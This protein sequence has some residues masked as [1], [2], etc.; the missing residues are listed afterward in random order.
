MREEGPEKALGA[1][2]SLCAFALPADSGGK[3]GRERG[4]EPDTEE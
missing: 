3:V 1:T 4:G 2:H